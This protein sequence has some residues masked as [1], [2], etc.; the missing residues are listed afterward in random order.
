M[1][2]VAVLLSGGV[3]SSVSLSILKDLGFNV[4]AFYL[5]I[6]LEDELSFLG[7]CPWEEDMDYVKKTCELLNVELEIVTMQKTYHEKI[8]T[9]VIDSVKNGLTPNPDI[10]CNK[11]IKFGLFFDLFKNDFDYFATGHYAQNINENRIFF[12]KMA[13]DEFKD[14]TYFLSQVDYYRL[15]KTIFP[16]GSMKKD[17]VRK[18]ALEKKLPAS[19]RKDSQGI[20]FLGKISFKDFLKYHLGTSSG[21]IY[22]YETKKKVGKHDGFWF[23]TIGQRQGIG[24][25]GGPWYVVKKNCDENVIFVSSNYYSKDKK[26][27]DVFVKNINWLVHNECRPKLNEKVFIKIRHGEKINSAIIKDISDKNLYRFIL[28]ENDQGIALGQYLVMYNYDKICL[29]GG[30]ITE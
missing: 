24:L 8:V 26:R 29:G 15:S 25:A 20:C 28:D 11:N 23:Y 10:L 14:Q 7:N 4:K 22:E 12:L 2:T 3:D 13:V 1:K 30:V 21:D 5:K 9:Y 16:I 27:N 17:D 19:N 6:W 18:Y